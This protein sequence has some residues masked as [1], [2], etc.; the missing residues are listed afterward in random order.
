MKAAIVAVTPTLTEE[1]EK[2]ERLCRQ[3]GELQKLGL[4]KSVSIASV[5]HPDLYPFP[6]SYYQLIKFGLTHKNKKQLEDFMRNKFEFKKV[7]MLSS[8]S[9]ENLTLAEKL[10]EFAERQRA[11]LLVVNQTR[12]AG[13]FK[14]LV[15]RVAEVTAFSAALPVLVLHSDSEEAKGGFEPRILLAVDARHLPSASELEYVANAARL[16]GAEV[17]I[18]HVRPA[19]RSFSKPL[20]LRLPPSL[21]MRKLGR[22]ETYFARKCVSARSAMVEEDESI[23]AAIEQYAETHRMCMSVVTLPVRPYLRRLLLGSTAKRLLRISRRPVFVLRPN[24]SKAKAQA[25]KPEARALSFD[26]RN[27]DGTIGELELLAK[28]A[29]A[30]QNSTGRG[31]LA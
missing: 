29:E 23:A 4:L 28:E 9:S 3:I 16:M 27:L 17:H 11:D 18:V 30:R 2:L 8:P 13:W 15:H 21:V 19:N 25:L 5:M 10:S 1:P 26:R 6:A 24:P 14:S 31:I 20:N 7:H 22:L 12:N